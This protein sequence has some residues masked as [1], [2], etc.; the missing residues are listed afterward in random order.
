MQEKLCFYYSAMKGGKT[1][2]IF[3]KI[4][5]LEEIGQKVLLIKP[6]QDTKGK[7][8]IVNRLNQT[9]TVDI[10]LPPTS[11]IVTEETF[12]KIYECNHIIVDEA[13]FLI[14]EQI[15]EL[16][17]IN[18]NANIP[19][20]CFGLLTNFRGELFPGAKRLIELA[21]ERLELG[22]N[23]LCTCGAPAKFNAR[24]VNGEFTMKGAE[25][26][27]DGAS[28]NIEY[29]PLCGTCYYNKVYRKGKK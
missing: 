28:S 3:S 16:W 1:S 2:R 12:D 29:V 6:R 20:T 10:L 18:K 17:T 27:I 4:H 25:V 21:D 23:S 19:I 15:E 5:D 26:E 11:K 8:Q 9:R 24:K 13:Q 7:N 22:T 14:P